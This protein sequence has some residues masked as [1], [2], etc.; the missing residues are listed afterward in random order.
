M[1]NLQL[2]DTSTKLLLERIIAYLSENG[3]DNMDDPEGYLA[4]T[5]TPSGTDANGNHWAR[6]E[7]FWTVY[8]QG[9]YMGGITV[10]VGVDP[11]DEDF[12][13]NQTVG[14]INAQITMQVGEIYHLV[15]HYGWSSVVQP[16]IRVLLSGLDAM[17]N[18][19]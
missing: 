8:D 15:D 16:Q 17:R 9:T 13:E 3:F 4:S 19:C 1:F 18:E 7:T 10:I 2:L 14:V 11:D 5:A 12:D 6:D